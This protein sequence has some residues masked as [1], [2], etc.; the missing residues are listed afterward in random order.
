MKNRRALVL[1]GGGSKGAYQA[2]VIYSLCNEKG[3]VYDAFYGISVGAINAS[4]MTQN[5]SQK[6]GSKHLISMWQQIENKDVKK[7]W[8]PFSFLTGL[9]K[10]S[11]Y[12]SKP[13]KE[14]IK[15]NFDPSRAFFPCFVGAVSLNTKQIK[16]FDCSKE[17]AVN[18][19]LASSAF[20]GFLEAK[21]IDE[22]VYVDGGVRDITPI[23]IA[24]DDGATEI[25]VI[26]ASNPFAIPK[27]K[28]E[29]FNAIEVILETIDAMTSEIM[30][31]DVKIANM[32]NELLEHKKV[33]NK[34][35]VKINF[36]YPNNAFGVSTLDFDPKGIDLMIKRGLEDGR[37]VKF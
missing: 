16:Y 11:L 5:P 31:N 35:K 7:H 34:R 14:L 4:A 21:E 36:I 26:M 3:R 29:K 32:Y 24:I 27:G 15:N 6:M 28:K 12:N 22:N 8:L 18:A 13:L 37:G 25:D 17:N 23:K 33:E 10:S 1:S 2:G 30:I 20:P 19:I 9:W